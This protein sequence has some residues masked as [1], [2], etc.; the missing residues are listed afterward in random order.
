MVWGAYGPLPPPLQSAPD[1]LYAAYH[2]AR[3]PTGVPY[4]GRL[5]AK[6]GRVLQS[7]GVGAQYAVHHS[8][9][10]V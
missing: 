9:K 8:E 10:N 3:L 4:D 7:M 1:T 6:S 2:P 5:C